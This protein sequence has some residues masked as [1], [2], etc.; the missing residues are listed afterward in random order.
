MNFKNCLLIIVS[1]LITI[2]AC[3]KGND[4]T[5]G[6]NPNPNPN[7]NPAPSADTTLKAVASFPIGIAIDYDLFKNNPSYKNIVAREADQTTFG[8]SMK[9]GAIVKDDGSF[10]YSRADELL[11]LA[12]NAGL[13]VFGHTLAW[14]SNQNGNYLR[15]LTVDAG[16]TGAANLLSDGD[17]E[18][19]TGT[20][21]TGTTLFTGWSVLIGGNAAGSFAAVAGNNST[22]ALQTTVTTPG[23][24]A[25]DVQ[26]LGPNWNAAVGT[27]Y[28]VSVDIKASVTNGSVRLVN[29]NN[30]YQAT[31]ITPTASWATYTWTLTA[32]ETSPSL[33]LNFPVAGVY[34]I[35]NIKINEVTPGGQLPAAQAAANV[36]S[37][38]SRFIRSTVTRYAG[39]VKAWDVVNEAFNDGTGT[40]RTTGTATNDAF[41]W[42]QYLG[43]DFALKAFNYTKTADPTALLFIND[44]NLESDSR[45]L[46]SLIAFVNELKSKGAKVDGIGSQMHI[47]IN[48]S[49]T[50]I[51]NMFVKL[52]ATGLKIRVSELD[53]RINP[54]NLTGFTPSAQN[55]S[56]QAA[57]YKYVAESFIRNV[58]A[59]QRYDFTIWG[60]ADNDSWIVTALHREDFPLLFNSNYSKKP[61]FASL[62]QG[63]KQ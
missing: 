61:A 34:T 1:G 42:A 39:K 30:Q 28:K 10:D 18:G 2:T 15:S 3:K 23:T 50:A 33:R 63:L 51:D 44:Y 6:T 29:Q 24:N 46:D 32:A 38:M 59:A 19:G 20:S 37:A 56:D 31:D 21:G 49:K 11:N 7:P 22:R 45:K 55:L 35:D 53:I 57:M 40:I 47:S 5:S 41:Y 9:H 27:Q 60:V 54:N 13:Q 12:T 4:A 8:Y 26:A 62:L 43:R 36:D 14:H 58:P 17:F 25:W 52:A 48:T 16:T